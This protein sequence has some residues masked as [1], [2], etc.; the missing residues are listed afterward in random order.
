MDG[1]F[2]QE[3]NTGG[4]GMIL[5]K[6][7]GTIIYTSCWFLRKCHSALEAEIAALREGIELALEWSSLPLII[8]SD[9]V[10][11]VNMIKNHALDRSSLAATVGEI[12]SML[13]TGGREY[14]LFH[15]SRTQN[16]ISHVLGQLGRAGPKTAVWLRGG[17]DEIT[18]LVAMECN[19]P[20]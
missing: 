13:Q 3:E 8:E 5:R 4:A 14:S 16:N 6:S 15:M 17:P 1:A 10:A 19:I 18:D 11:T 7:D 2:Q 20:G 12:K 9:C